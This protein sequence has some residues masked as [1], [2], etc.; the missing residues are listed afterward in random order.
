MTVARAS[1]A[2][3]DTLITSDAAG[4]LAPTSRLSTPLAFYGTNRTAFNFGTDSGNATME[5]ILEGNPASTTSAYLAV[6]AN[7]SSNLRY[8]LYNN[9][10]QL[11]FTQLGI[12]DYL[13]SPGDSLP[14]A[15]HPHH[16]RLERGQPDH[17]S[18]PQRGIGGHAI[19]GRC[20]L[21]NAHG[22]GL[23]RRQPE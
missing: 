16:L 15:S 4:G 1:L 14:H 13:F 3:Y 22:S 23:A 21:R 5:F 12:A 17:E 8:E 7:S 19:L 18:L 9:T 11:G 20:R 6:G 10:G 2:T